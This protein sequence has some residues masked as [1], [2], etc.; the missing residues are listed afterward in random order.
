M[1]KCIVCGDKSKFTINRGTISEVKLCVAHYDN[2]YTHLQYPYH[3]V[4]E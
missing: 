2:K 3:G 4:I 1:N